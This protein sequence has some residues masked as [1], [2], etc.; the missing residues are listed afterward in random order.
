MRETRQM[1]KIEQYIY[2]WIK[3]NLGLL[4]VIAVTAI[5][6]WICFYLRRYE[7]TFIKIC[8]HGLKKSRQ[9]V[10]GRQW[11]SRLATIIFFIRWSLQAWPIFHL[12]HYICIRDYRFSLIFFWR[13][14][15]VFS[16]VDWETVRR[17]C[18]LQGY[19]QQFYYCRL[20]IWIQL[21]GHSV[22]LFILLL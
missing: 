17:R 10:V 3:K 14:H 21:H 11:N 12:K 9:M 1:T 16:S 19:T 5:H 6:L 13:E 22:I 7:E 4:C 20:R 2:D 8:S 15:V 18:C